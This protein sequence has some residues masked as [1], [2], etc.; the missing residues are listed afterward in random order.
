MKT[1]PGNH[2]HNRGL[3]LAENLERAADELERLSLRAMSLGE[4]LEVVYGMMS[5]LRP[6]NATPVGVVE[7]WHPTV[8]TGYLRRTAQEVR[9][10]IK[11]QQTPKAQEPKTSRFRDAD[12]FM[13]EVK[14]SCRD[15]ARAV[16]QVQAIGLEHHPRIRKEFAEVFFKRADML[17]EILQERLG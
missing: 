1:A 11:K 2:L 8:N 15:I 7:D 6:G 17:R 16:E 3:V 10:E 14:Q 13:E 12:H 4:R 9:D 5:I